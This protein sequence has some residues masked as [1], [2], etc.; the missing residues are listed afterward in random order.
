MT[1]EELRQ[2]ANGLY[3]PEKVHSWEATLIQLELLMRLA[4]AQERI[5]FALERQTGIGHTDLF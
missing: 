4:K 5:A 3:A 1:I 2:K